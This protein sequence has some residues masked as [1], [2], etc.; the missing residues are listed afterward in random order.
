[1]K[2]YKRIETDEGRE[3]VQI[4]KVYQ[5]NGGSIDNDGTLNLRFLIEREEHT[6]EMSIHEIGMLIEKLAWALQHYGERDD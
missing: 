1:M 3:S 6:I 4:C 2:V 5:T